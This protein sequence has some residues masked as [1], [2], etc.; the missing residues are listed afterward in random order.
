MCSTEIKT[1]NAI[2]FNL[3]HLYL[4]SCYVFDF[5]EALQLVKT[6]ASH[7]NEAMSKIVSGMLFGL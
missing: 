5:P 6:A 1:E 4:C 2:S 7:S 3:F